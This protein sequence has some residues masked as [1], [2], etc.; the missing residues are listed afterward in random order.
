ME[1]QVSEM[2]TV[3]SAYMKG[4]DVLNAKIQKRDKTIQDLEE[5]LGKV[6]SEHGRTIS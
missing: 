1:G 5:L 6:Q 2:E 3:L 4:E